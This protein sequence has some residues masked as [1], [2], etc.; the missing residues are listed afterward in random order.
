MAAASVR[1]VDFDQDIR[2]LLQQHCVECHGEKKQKGELRLDAKVFAFKGGHD[3]PAIVAGN[4]GKSLLY[5]RIASAQEDERMPPKGDPLSKAQIALIQSWIASGAVWPENAADKAATTD[6]RLQHWAVQ[7]VAPQAQKASIDSWINA[8]LA[9]KNLTMSPQADRRT[10]IR[11]LSFDLLGLPPAPERVEQFVKDAD[12]QAYE[13]LVDELLRSPHYGERW[14]RHWLDIAHYADTHGFERD[15][16]RPN[17]WRYRD[18]VI[19]SLNA[20]KPY[21]QFIREQIAGDVIAPNDPQ[22]VIATG[23]VAAGPWDFVGQVETKSEMLRRAA[24][25]GDL[26]DMVTQVITST[27]GITINCARCHDHKLDPITQEEYYR[28]WAVFA[29]VKRGDR[30]VDVAEAKRVAEEKVRLSKELAQTRAQIAKLAGEGLDLAAMVGGGVKGRG[31]DL[32]T[33]NLT[34]NK[35]GY[36]RDIQTNRL[37]RIEWPA[38]VA[39]TDRFVSW[40]FVPDGRNPVPVAPKLEVKGL[41]ATGGHTWDIIRNGP[42]NAQRSTKIAGVDYAEKD[43]SILGLHA[44]SGITF[45]LVKIRRSSGLGAMRLAA[46]LGFG[47]DAGAAASRA[48]FTVHVDAERKFQKLKM[49]KDEFTHLDIAIP[50]AAKTLTLIATDG[51]DGIGSDLLFL[52]DARL[53]PEL[54]HSRL[55]ASDQDKLKQLRAQAA[56]LDAG[57]KAQADPAKV[58]AVVSEAQPPVVRVQRRGNPEDPQQ[59]VQPGAFA[60]APHASCDFGTNETPEGQR[61][62]L[63][64]EWI[65]HPANPLT[66]RVLVNRLWH[67]HF[68]QGIVTTPSDFGLGGDRPS[69]PELL[70]WLAAEF[71][72]GGWSVKHMHKIIVMSAAYQQQSVAPNE[73]AGRIDAQNRLLWRQNPRRLDAESLHDTVLSVAGTLNPAMGG[74]GYRDFNYTEAYAPIYDYLTPDKPELLRR[75]I[76]RFVVRT[77]PHQFMSTLDCPDPANLTPARAQTTTALQALTLSNNEFMLQQAASLATRIEN[78]TDSRAASIRR[79]FQLCFQRAPSE[80]EQHAATGLVTEQGLFALCRMLMNANEFVYID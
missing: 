46:A 10:L 62:R 35:L 47:A 26:D 70:D 36:H 42:L 31:I 76:Y 79:A 25:A 19:Q 12:P 80:E 66:S 37:Q 7:P 50:A 23:F 15:Q 73:T 22:A 32:R 3:G 21:D 72:R 41:P 39:D 2:P 78:E 17:A 56:R 14:A 1:A 27:M 43:H 13:K 74:P 45:D 57:L 67:H 16:L 30:D 55:T 11:R 60:W 38:E 33:G 69:N 40:V 68:G 34:A 54:E 63:L 64:A 53:V 18:Y 51:G 59:E 24:R 8:K 58:Y 77:T 71:Q 49:R 65:T 9:E 6:K 44:N 5:Q 48:D 20:D 29:G 4:A 28:L 75:S 61:R 52:G